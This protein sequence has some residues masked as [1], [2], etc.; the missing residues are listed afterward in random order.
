MGRGRRIGRGGGKGGAGLFRREANEARRLKLRQRLVILYRK[1]CWSRIRS[2]T[3]L[4]CIYMSRADFRYTGLATAISC[5]N[6]IVPPN[7]TSSS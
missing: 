4:I 3:G 5:I 2:R 6:H 7:I 1:H